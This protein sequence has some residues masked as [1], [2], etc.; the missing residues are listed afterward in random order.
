MVAPFSSS[1]LIKLVSAFN[2]GYLKLSPLMISEEV[3]ISYTSIGDYAAIEII[4]LISIIGKANAMN[5]FLIIN[6]NFYKNYLGL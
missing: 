5:K 2:F 6:L 4:G 1:T 3:K